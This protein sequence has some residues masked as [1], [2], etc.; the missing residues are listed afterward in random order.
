MHLY[1]DGDA[2]NETSGGSAEVRNAG[3]MVVRLVIADFADDGGKV[4]G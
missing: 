4:R 3:P 1:W 2:D